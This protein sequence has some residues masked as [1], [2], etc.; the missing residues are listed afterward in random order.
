MKGGISIIITKKI[1]AIKYTY[2]DPIA[3]KEGSSSE[4]I[5]WFG[6]HNKV[7]VLHTHGASY[8]RNSGDYFS[9]A[10]TDYADKIGI[11]IYVATPRGTL[12]KYNP[13]DET[14][15]IIYWDLPYDPNH[16]DR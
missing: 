16:P 1:T 8:G 11:P 15:I 7:G 10:D 13:A 9:L 6:L 5:N 14:D 3:G 4:P 12:R 2:R